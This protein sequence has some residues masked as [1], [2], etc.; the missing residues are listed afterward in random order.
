MV[1]SHHHIFYGKLFTVIIRTT[2]LRNHIEM[3][4]NRKEFVRKNKLYFIA[5][6]QLKILKTALLMCKKCGNDS[7]FAA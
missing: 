4:L 7:L 1:H 6:V 2:R 5:S 3:I